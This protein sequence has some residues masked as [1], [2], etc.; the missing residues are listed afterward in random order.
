MEPIKVNIKVLPHARGLPL[1]LYATSGSAGMDLRAAI[2]KPLVLAPGER[3][4]IPTGLQ[5][6]LP[7]HHEAQIRPRSGWALSR[8]ITVANAPGTIDSDYR[9]EI[10]V[11][12]INLDHQS[13]TIRRGDR[14]AQMIVAPVT[15]VDWS[16]VQDLDETR[17]SVGGFGSTGTR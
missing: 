16:P 9:G 4:A 17:R 11:A 15:R 1:P 14:I 7:D 10:L 5:I 12:L 2:D 13:H 8:G 3:A 6:A